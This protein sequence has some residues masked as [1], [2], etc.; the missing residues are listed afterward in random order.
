MCKAMHYLNVELNII[1]RDLKAAN[2]F[3]TFDEIPIAKVGDFGTSL[4]KITS[5][6]KNYF[7]IGTVGWMV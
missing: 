6:R 3:L 1:H 4:N 2:V 7:E 5:F